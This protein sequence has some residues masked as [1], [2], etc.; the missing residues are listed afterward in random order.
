M[1]EGYPLGARWRVVVRLA[2]AMPR[3]VEQRRGSGRCV[4]G[5]L[6][7][8]RTARSAIFQRLDPRV[9]LLWLVCFFLLTIAAGRPL[10]IGLL[11]L[12]LLLIAAAAGATGRV[13]RAVLPLAWVILL[14]SV[15]NG[16]AY[17]V[18]NGLLTA[19][20]FALALGGFAAF[21]AVSDVDDLADALAGLGVPDRFAFVLT[22]GLAL[23]PSVARE[24]TE[25]VD[26]YRARGIPLD[27]QWWRRLT[28]YPRL[29]FP[30]VVGTVGRALR[31]AAA[32]EVRGF[33]AVARRTPLT[34]LRMTGRDWA[35]TLAIILVSLVVLMGFA[36]GGS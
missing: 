15:M 36:I 17:G 8:G 10:Q 27:E 13:L 16:I 14:V 21:F 35:T 33:G 19:A 25:I 30:L 20:R 22:G 34:E 32:L 29:L 31:L 26:A 2:S 18:E 7:G 12:W 1:L 11:A 24:F 9:R 28:I 4:V 23:V 3:H 5:V 6:A